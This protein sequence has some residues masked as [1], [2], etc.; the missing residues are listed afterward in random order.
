MRLEETVKFFLSLTSSF[1][2]EEAEARGLS[3]LVREAGLD[4]DIRADVLRA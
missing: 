1:I 2:N 4:L 3:D